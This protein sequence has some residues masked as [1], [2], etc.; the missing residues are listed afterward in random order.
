MRSNS[1]GKLKDALG[2]ACEGTTRDSVNRQV[3]R[4]VRWTV[5]ATTPH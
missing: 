3:D 5:N 4:A 1:P 2:W